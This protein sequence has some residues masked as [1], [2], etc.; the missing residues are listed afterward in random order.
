ML[1]QNIQDVVVGS[2]IQFAD[3][4]LLAMLVCQVPSVVFVKSREHIVFD[5][6]DSD[7]GWIAIMKRCC[8]HE[9]AYNLVAFC[10]FQVN[11]LQTVPGS[12]CGLT[13][14]PAPAWLSE[15]EI[16][17]SAMVCNPLARTLR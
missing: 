12:I 4:R 17:A 13:R 6:S 1:V 16:L 7:N 11:V 15:S 14:M 8:G 2:M 5:S 9:L 3:F 10:A